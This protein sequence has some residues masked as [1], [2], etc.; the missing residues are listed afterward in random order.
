MAGFKADQMAALD[1]TS[2]AAL[3]S[4]KVSNLAAD[5]MAGFDNL[6]LNRPRSNS[7][8]GNAS[9]SSGRS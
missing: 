5:A 8:R 6:K 4:T 3:D 1:T 9:R 2:V 7:G